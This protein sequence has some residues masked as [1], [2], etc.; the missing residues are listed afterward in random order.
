MGVFVYITKIKLS[1][2]TLN[3]LYNYKVINIKEK[4]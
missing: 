3:S 2:I 4:A 1:K